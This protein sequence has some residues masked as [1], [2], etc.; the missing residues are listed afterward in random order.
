MTTARRNT[1]AVLAILT[2]A[3]I[4]LI[5]SIGTTPATAQSPMDVHIDI[6]PHTIVLS[7]AAECVTVH[8]EIAL[9]AVD[10][11]SVRLEH[12]TP[13]LVKADSRGELVAKF[14]S[15]AV[16][17]IVAPPS[18]TMTLTGMTK[19]GQPFSGTATVAVRD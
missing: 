15:E 1:Y 8:A 7:S 17:A 13:Y 16:K 5:S 4:L 11:G 19:D 2:C 14:D 9:S 10:A 12:L 6:A 18:A 3:G